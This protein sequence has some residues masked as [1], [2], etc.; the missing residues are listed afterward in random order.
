LQ[1]RKQGFSEDYEE[2]SDGIICYAYP[3]L[4]KDKIIG[5]ISSSLPSARRNK[6]SKVRQI[7]QNAA[8]KFENLI[9]ENLYISI[10]NSA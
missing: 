2:F 9:D 8:K 10:L 3:I 7:L 4:L 6:Y 5:C 1:I